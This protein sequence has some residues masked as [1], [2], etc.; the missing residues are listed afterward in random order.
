M[1]AIMPPPP[2][3]AKR[4]R[5]PEQGA[6]RNRAQLKRNIEWPS[7]DGNAI[8]WRYC[9]NPLHAKLRAAVA[10]QAWPHRAPKGRANPQC[11]VR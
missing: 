6:G 9:A 2:S 4:N 5:V 7:L 1:P 3:A 10:R 8:S 11:T